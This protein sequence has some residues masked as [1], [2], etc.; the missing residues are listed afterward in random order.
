VAVVRSDNIYGGGDFNWQRLVPGA[1]RSL[2]KGEPPVIRGTGLLQ[3]D[4]V[5]VDDAV[6]AYLA[7][8]ERLDRADVSRKLFR[9]ATGKTAGALDV[10]NRLVQLSGRADL[11]PRVLNEIQDER[12]DTLYAPTIEKN[13]LGWTSQVTLQD[14]LARAYAWYQKFF[15]TK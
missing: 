2:L 11:K 4:Y 1:I 13:V 10:V 3:R 6:A 5:Y 15:Q 9:V 14:G 12:V 8:A 7:V